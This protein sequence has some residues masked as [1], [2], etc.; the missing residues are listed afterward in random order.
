MSTAT[1]TRESLIALDKLKKSPRNARQQPHTK[2]EVEQLAAS[3]A[4][5]GLI[6]N[7][8]VEPELE[9]NKKTGFYLVTAGEGRRLAHVLL[10]KR[11]A[12]KPNVKVRCVIE[13][14][15]NA[16]EI[17]LAENTIRSDMHPAD[18]YEA[19]AKLHQDGMPVEDIGAK[20]GVTP[21]VVTQRLKLGGVSPK[22]IKAYRAG[23]MTLDQ[24][25]AFTI[26]DDFKAQERVWNQL[27]E[28]NR[29]RRTILAALTETQVP[30]DDRRALYIGAEAY[31]AA[32]GKVLRDL[33]DPEGAGFFDNPELLD[34]LV[35]EKLQRAA[36]K[37]VAEGWKWINVD[38]TFDH[39]GAATMRRVTPTLAAE[40]QA[41]LDTLNAQLEALYEGTED[42]S[43]DRDIQDIEGKIEA[44]QARECFAAPDIARAGAFICLGHRGETRIE[45]GFVRKEDWID[46]EGAQGAS[47][48][49]GGE[50]PKQPKLLADSLVLEL[51]TH[52]TYALRNELAERSDVALTALLHA[53]VC[54]LLYHASDAS[55]LEVS[56]R[57][58]SL[59]N[60]AAEIADGEAGR[61]IAARQGAWQKKLP[62]A[63]DDLWDVLT[64]MAQAEQLELLAH[65]V[66]L[67]IDAAH[68]NRSNKPH[69][70]MLASALR[71]DMS[72]Y[73]QPTVANYLGRVS[74]DRVSEAVSE[75]VSLEAA[76]N[77]GGLKKQAM[78][79][80]AQQRL[81]GR[82]WLPPILRTA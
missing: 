23:D 82:N 1:Q 5:V 13:D 63:L 33:F 37:V 28:Y 49:D 21:A 46:A 80:A 10:V 44:V 18:Q 58:L 71:L 74:K 3:I 15:G 20:F 70:N 78:A 51:T 52:R 76:V 47:N 25:T 27:P 38:P 39:E 48:E 59:H 53:L 54:E 50:A 73:W 2:E 62:E 7:L 72:H 56:A 81:A 57:H 11:K 79:E 29:H 22:L 36:R 9:D 66:S 24:L 67:T 69:A 41:E 12:M 77:L 42:A 14:A 61:R 60:H 40:D 31:E 55:C 35:R 17:S 75:G 68:D 65:C 8:V 64:G 32:G 26:T 16:R 34:R 43:E 45:R 6:Q 4:S 30:G 19:F